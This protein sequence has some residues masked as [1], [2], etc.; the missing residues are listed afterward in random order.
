M[1]DLRLVTVKK[2]YEITGLSASFFK[3]LIH[4]GKLKR[5]KVN[6]ATLISLTEFEQ[7]AQPGPPSLGKNHIRASVES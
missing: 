7:F 1:T 5:H 4:D 2:A 3:K 6:T